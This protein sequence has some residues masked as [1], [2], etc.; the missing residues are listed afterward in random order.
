MPKSIGFLCLFFSIGSEGVF[1]ECYAV[2]AYAFCNALGAHCSDI[3]IVIGIAGHTS[4]GAY[5]RRY[6]TVTACFGERYLHIP[7]G[8][9]Y[10]FA[11]YNCILIGFYR[12]TDKDR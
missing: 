8:T 3:Y 1:L 6:V 5:C 2:S 9:A 11:E 4:C 12:K 7:Y 10:F